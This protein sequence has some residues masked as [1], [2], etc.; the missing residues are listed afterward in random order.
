MDNEFYY[1]EKFTKSQAWIDLLL[2]A[3]HKAT[4]IFIRGIQ[5]KLN[6]GDL[7]YS[8]LTL[9]KR[10]KWDFKTVKKFLDML[11]QRNMIQYAGGKITTVI[12]VANWSNYQKNGEQNQPIKSI[13][14]ATFF[15]AEG[16]Q[17]GEQK[18]NNLETDNN[19]KNVKNIYEQEFETFWNI[20]DKKVDKEKCIKKWNNLTKSDK[21]KI[22]S[23][24]PNYIS[25]T[26]DKQYRKNP[27][28]YLN[29]KCW[30][31]EIEQPKEQILNLG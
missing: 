6:P 14:K 3:N 25:K 19:D 8:Q 31:D 12:S 10:W 27:L 1:S 30:N 17:L 22:L 28:T 26:P 21:E 5:I 2:L 16:E 4:T 7:C 24:L 20:Y 18:E 13:S 23:T 9:A 15:D 29:G 11:K